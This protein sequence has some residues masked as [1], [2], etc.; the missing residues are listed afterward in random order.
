MD[1]IRSAL[2][3]FVG[4]T[5][6]LSGRAEWQWG[7]ELSAKGMINHPCYMY[8]YH[9]ISIRLHVSANDVTILY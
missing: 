2:F 1:I 3:V 4:E 7:G 5:V 8:I 6:E 9:M